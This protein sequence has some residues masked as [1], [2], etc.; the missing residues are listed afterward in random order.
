MRL[1]NVDCPYR[2]ILHTQASGMETGDCKC[3]GG[4]DEIELNEFSE[5][6]CGCASVALLKGL[7]HH[8]ADSRNG[9]CV[10]KVLVGES[11]RHQSRAK[12]H[13]EDLSDNYA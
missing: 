4:K 6:V 2:D 7:I 9:I 10:R 11:T 5:S 3:D 12:P 13:H 1:G 8:S